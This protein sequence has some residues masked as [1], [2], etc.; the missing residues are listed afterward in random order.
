MDY[1]ITKIQCF[2]APTLL[3]RSHKKGTTLLIGTH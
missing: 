3:I 1:K 2:L